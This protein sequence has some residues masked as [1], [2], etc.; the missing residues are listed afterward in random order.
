MLAGMAKEYSFTFKIDTTKAKSLVHT[1]IPPKK[2]QTKKQKQKI[3]A[4]AIVANKLSEGILKVYIKSW[5][6]RRYRLQAR[7]IT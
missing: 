5:T 6:V 2:K 4:R 3:K 7:S 1:G